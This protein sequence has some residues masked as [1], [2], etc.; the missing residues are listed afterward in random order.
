MARILDPTNTDDNAGYEGLRTLLSV[1]TTNANLDADPL[2]RLS[3]DEIIAR[4]PDAADRNYANRADV[5][6]AL[7]FCASANFL[8][9]G[10]SS[11]E[12]SETV[13]GGAVKSITESVGEISKSTT[14]TEGGTRSR[15]GAKTDPDDRS[16]FFREKCE[17]ILKRLGAS[18]PESSD[19]PFVL[20]TDS[21]LT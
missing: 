14:Y 19:G 11:T 7:Q 12:S 13:A 21:R 4:L 3:E 15:G 8:E 1:E 10:G 16:T 20:L 5:I 17:A 2:F 9:G 18:E 6:T